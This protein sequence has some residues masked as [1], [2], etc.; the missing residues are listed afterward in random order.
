M[1]DEQ[2]P[3]ETT[4]TDIQ[5]QTPEVSDSVVPEAATP[6]VPEQPAE[7]DRGD[8]RIA[9]MEERRKRQEYEAM[10]NDPQWVYQQA[11][12]LG[13]AQEE[14]PSPAPQLP[15]TPSQAPLDPTV[16]SSVVEHQLDFRETV[17]AHPEFDP[18][19][20]DKGLVTWAAA[21][22][23]QG[24]KPSQ[25]VDIILKT[26]DRRTSQATT[27]QVEEKMNR[28]SEAEALKMSAESVSSTVNTDQNAQEL[29]DLDAR[30][31]NWKDPRAQEAAVLEKLRRGMR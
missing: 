1:A 4:A 18:R 7:P 28:Q 12:R 13:L 15:E 24:H 31:K 3:A 6:A 14:T 25:A 5:E 20:G 17:K 10:H 30:A 29:A 22:V 2:A 19:S 9:M 21:L 16:I 27:E 8:P 11:Q 26:I 23:D